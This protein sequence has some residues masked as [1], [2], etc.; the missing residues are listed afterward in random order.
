MPIALDGHAAVASNNG[1]FIYVTGGEEVDLQPTVEIAEVNKETGELTWLPN[2]AAFATKRF[3]HCLMGIGDTLWLVGGLTVNHAPQNDVQVAT[4]D[5][6]SGAVQSWDLL[7]QTS[8][9]PFTANRSGCAHAQQNLVV[10]GGQ[11]DGGGGPV[12]KVEVGATAGLAITGWTE[13]AMGEGLFTPR[14]GLC[15]AVSQDGYIY[16]AGG[17]DYGGTNVTSVESAPG[18]TPTAFSP[19]PNH[20]QVG[21]DEPGCAALGGFLFVAGGVNGGS[22]Y[23]SDVEMATIAE[24]VVGPWKGAGAFPGGAQRSSLSLVAIQP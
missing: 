10:I 20:L 6:S 3:H 14:K 2:G 4:F 13:S 22:D 9:A 5:P 23:R 8:M 11:G 7:D 18:A 24:G 17:Q 1:Q 19:S 12:S 21:R 16:V 15:A